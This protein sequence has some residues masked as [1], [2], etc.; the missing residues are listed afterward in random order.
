[1]GRTSTTKA[2]RSTKKPTSRINKARLAA[3]V[4]EATVDCYDE[5]EQV[6]GLF[7]MIEENL[8]VPFA[9]MVL[10]MPVT[11]EHVELKHHDQIVAIC[12]RAR[13]RQAISILDLPLPSRPPVGAEWIEAYRHWVNGR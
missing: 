8:E 2:G 6:T 13:A 7:T 3:M 10:G 11:V 12:E 9:T 5:S 1:M 4:E